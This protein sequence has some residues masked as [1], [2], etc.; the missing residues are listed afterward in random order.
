[1]KFQSCTECGGRCCTSFGVLPEYRNRIHVG[2]VPLDN[3]KSDLDMNPRRY[4][5]IH[6][7]VIISEDGQRFT[8]NRNIRVRGIDGYLIVESPCIMLNDRGRCMIYNERP[9]MCMNFTAENAEFYIVPAGCKYEPE[10][11]PISP[12]GM[13]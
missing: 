9:D 7:G 3:F 11:C 6:E 8:V 5:E 4:F 1:M 12:A 10:L 13:E 2:G